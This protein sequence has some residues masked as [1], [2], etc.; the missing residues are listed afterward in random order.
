MT[1]PYSGVNTSN[2]SK[3]PKKK[4]SKN[5]IKVVVNGNFEVMEL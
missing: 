1:V 5:E 4:G 2:F 3:N